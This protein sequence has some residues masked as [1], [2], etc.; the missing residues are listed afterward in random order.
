M[1]DWLRSVIGKTVAEKRGKLK[2]RNKH[3]ALNRS[4]GR[5]TNQFYRAERRGLKVASNIYAPLS[6]GEGRAKP[7]NPEAQRASQR[8]K[9]TGKKKPFVRPRKGGPFTKKEKK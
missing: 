2:T 1:R 6:S 9:G 5:R 8:S 7:A 3:D 4:S